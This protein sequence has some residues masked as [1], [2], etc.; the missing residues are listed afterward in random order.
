MVLFH[1]GRYFRF[2]LSDLDEAILKHRYQVKTWFLRDK[3]L[4]RAIVEK[5]LDIDGDS[6]SVFKQRGTLKDYSPESI[7]AY[8]MRQAR[9]DVGPGIRQKYV[10][11]LQ[12]LELRLWRLKKKY[13][14]RGT[15]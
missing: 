8:M 5:L 6:V 1:G 14:K 10:N 11:K 15:T 3:E 13:E 7:R 9:R 2:L 4:P 12:Q